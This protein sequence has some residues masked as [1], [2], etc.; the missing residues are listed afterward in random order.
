MSSDPKRSLFERLFSSLLL[1]CAFVLRVLSGIIKH[2]STAFLWIH[3]VCF[4][5]IARP[6][7]ISIILVRVRLLRWLA[8]ARG[9][10]FLLV[11]N[12]Y[13]LHTVV[14]CLVALVLF[15]QRGMQQTASASDM[16]RRTLLYTWVTDRSDD[17]TE[18]TPMETLFKERASHLADD[19]IIFFPGYDDDSNATADMLAEDTV[20]GSIS[21]I[22]DLDDDEASTRTTTENYAVRDGDTV[23]G[24][25]RRFQVDIPTIVAVNNLG[26]RAF[27]KPGM[28]L[29]IPA[30]SGVLHIIRSGD[31]LERI[32]SKYQVSAEA[33]AIANHV[34]SN[35]SLT[36]G[37][38]LLIPGAKVSAP[39]VKRPVAARPT[40]PASTIRGK[41]YDI[42]QE[43]TKQDERI[44]PSD[45]KEEAT[46]E[47]PKTKLFW[48]T[49]QRLIN[50]YYGWRHTGV[51]I[52]GDYTDPIYA[53]DDGVVEKAGWN[54][55]GYGLM[56][57]INHENGIK[58]RYAHASKM[59][60][61]AGDR[62]KRGQVIAMV[63]TTGRSTGTHLHYEVYINGR[64]ANP[65]TYTR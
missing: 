37:E 51:D 55:G 18:V 54:N 50:Q 63:G 36:I 23:A 11:A 59:F 64:R 26:T 52:N 45:A 48:P 2:V 46:P 58:T 33:V 21:A 9:W 30:A 57:F 5:R 61:A 8:S 20:P 32:A 19:T 56:I 12:R 24:I 35:S 22:S 53:S 27:I 15:T 17:Y 3:R 14:I 29:K 6:F 28:V 16:G 10:L 38:E 31:T 1:G 25:A 41:N 62:V 60:V 39:V 40:L 44:K 47:R 13:T 42:Y 4:L 7:Y 43:L 49:R 34:S 65:L